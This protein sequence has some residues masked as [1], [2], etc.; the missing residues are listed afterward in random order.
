MYADS[1]TGIFSPAVLKKIDEGKKIQ[2]TPELLPLHFRS[3]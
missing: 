1:Q 3:P 2:D